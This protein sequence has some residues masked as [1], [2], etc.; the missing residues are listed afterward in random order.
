MH[1]N[2]KA[3]AVGTNNQRTEALP[4]GHLRRRLGGFLL[5]NQETRPFMGT[6]TFFGMAAQIGKRTQEVRKAIHIGNLAFFLHNIHI[7]N[8]P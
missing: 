5:G 4:A 3:R 1:G 7:Q 8:W 2:A 6:K